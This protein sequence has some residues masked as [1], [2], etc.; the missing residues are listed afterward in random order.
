MKIIFGVLSSPGDGYSIMK[1]TWISIIK[2]YNKNNSDN[3]LECYFIESSDKFDIETVEGCSIFNFKV[4][5]EES[6]KNIMMKQMELFKYISK[7]YSNFIF[8][9]T[10]LSILWDFQKLNNWL[11]GFDTF[12]KPLFC[13]TFISTFEQ[14]HISGTTMT[15]NQKSLQVLIDNEKY[16]LD[17]SENDDVAISLLLTDKLQNFTF[18]TIPRIDFIEKSIVV[19]NKSNIDRIFVKRFKS[20]DRVFDANLMRNPDIELS[21]LRFQCPEYE[22]FF[23]NVYNISHS[24]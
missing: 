3:E 23:F 21:N 11:N 6:V 5:N 2:E 17:S 4:E 15:F 20:N 10:N 9:R 24:D 7:N 12:S 19:Y 16:L 22:K 8:I 1:E 18:R 14:F 13:G